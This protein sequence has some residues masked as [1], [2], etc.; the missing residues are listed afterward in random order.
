M[1]DPDPETSDNYKKIKA[2][3][4]PNPRKVF[5][6]SGYIKDGADDDDGAERLLCPHVLGYQHKGHSNETVPKERVL[7][8]Q[9]IGPGTDVD[10]PNWRCYMVD[11]LVNVEEA[12]D[13]VWEMGDG[14]SKR[15]NAVQNEKFQV[16]YPD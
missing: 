5:K 16:P 15:Q 1:P 2:W 10:D 8:W 12:T 4:D 3:L 6:V 9:I 13:E 11:S 7:C 14:Y